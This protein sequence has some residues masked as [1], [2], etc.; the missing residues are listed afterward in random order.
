MMNS[1][2]E[3]RGCQAPTGR[4]LTEEE[5]EK[6]YPYDSAKANFPNAAKDPFRTHLSPPKKVTNLDPVLQELKETRTTALQNAKTALAEAF[7]P[8]L[9]SMIKEKMQEEGLTTSDLNAIIE[10]VGGK[11]IVTPVTK[12]IEACNSDINSSPEKKKSLEE[13]KKLIENFKEKVATYPK[14]L[15]YEGAVVLCVM[16]SVNEAESINLDGMPIGDKALILSLLPQCAIAHL[17]RFDATLKVE[18]DSE[19]DFVLTYKHKN[20]PPV[21]LKFFNTVI[22]PNKLP[23]TAVPIEENDGK[24]MVG[25]ALVLDQK[26]IQRLVG[27]IP[28]EKPKREDEDDFP[29]R[30][31]V[32]GRNAYEIRADVLQMAFDWAAQGTKYTTPD[33]IIGVA[34]KFYEFVEDRKRR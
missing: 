24:V 19:R 6:F 22:H 28:H 8:R 25:S 31:P 7:V 18:F 21:A 29:R 12:V 23:D 9:N 16:L 2:P 3:E 32:S 10:E 14:Y 30:Q 27:I 11:P 5:I 1:T 33:D 13:T 20:E 17:K 4:P 34:K 26:R 15:T